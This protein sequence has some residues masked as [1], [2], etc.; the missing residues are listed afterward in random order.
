MHTVIACH[1]NK[2]FWGCLNFTWGGQACSV[3]SM[4][5]AISVGLEVRADSARPAVYTA[6]WHRLYQHSKLIVLMD[7]TR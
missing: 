3:S 2:V 1:D 7:Y 4:A 5:L 6:G